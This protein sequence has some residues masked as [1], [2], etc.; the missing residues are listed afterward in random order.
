MFIYLFLLLLLFLKPTC[1]F[2]GPSIPF[3][4]LSVQQPFAQV[5]SGPLLFHH[6]EALVGQPWAGC[7][8]DSVSSL[9]ILS[10]RAT[11]QGSTLPLGSAGI[12]L[13][14]NPTKQQ[15]QQQQMCISILHQHT[16]LG[17]VTNTRHID[18]T[19]QHHIAPSLLVMHQ[20]RST[21]TVRRRGVFFPLYFLQ[22]W[23][24]KTQHPTTK[25]PTPPSDHSK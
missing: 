4:L 6:G 14:G 15:Q 18:V 2:H 11:A 7:S 16:D 12:L 19:S 24:K 8:D 20:I 13:A 1:V 25:G 9:A 22:L 3:C 21:S 5:P 17:A 10:C 23:R